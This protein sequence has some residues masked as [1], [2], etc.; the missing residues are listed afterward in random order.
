VFVGVQVPKQKTK[1]LRAHDGATAQ[2]D[3]LQLLEP[4]EWISFVVG[5]VALG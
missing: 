1:Q 3:S 4:E 2:E 5:T